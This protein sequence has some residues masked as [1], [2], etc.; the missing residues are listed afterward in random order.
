MAKKAVKKDTRNRERTILPNGCQYTQPYISPANWKSLKASIKKPWFIRFTFYDPIH[1]PEGKEIKWEGMNGHKTLAARQDAAKLL[2]TV[3]PM[4]H[5]R[6]FA[7]AA[8]FVAV[9]QEK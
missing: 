3:A 6:H 5:V 4:R 9:G 1:R 2:V 8:M 7:K